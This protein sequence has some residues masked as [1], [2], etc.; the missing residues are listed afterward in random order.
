MEDNGFDTLIEIIVDNC[1]KI[2]LM[3][4]KPIAKLNNSEEI[5]Q[6]T[7]G[8]TNHESKREKLEGNQGRI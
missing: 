4:E 7:Q 2:I 1:P 8:V 5:G 3:K 6:P